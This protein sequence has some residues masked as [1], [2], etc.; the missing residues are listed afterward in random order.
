MDRCLFP[1]CWTEY[2]AAGWMTVV[3]MMPIVELLG[4]PGPFDRLGPPSGE[5]DGPPSAVGA[6]NTAS[7]GP[8]DRSFR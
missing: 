2:T 8:E 3:V 6:C 1:A 4:Q 5:R 7:T